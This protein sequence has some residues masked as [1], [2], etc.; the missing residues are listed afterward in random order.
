MAGPGGV[1]IFP[2]GN[3]YEGD[4]VDDMKVRRFL[5]VQPCMRTSMLVS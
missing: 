1:Y 2:D 4:W 3:K 5:C